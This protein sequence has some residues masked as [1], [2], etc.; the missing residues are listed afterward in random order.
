MQVFADGRATV[1]GWGVLRAAAAW[2]L[3][4]SEMSALAKIFPKFDDARPD[5]YGPG[6]FGGVSDMNC[7][8][9]MY[10]ETSS[11]VV[12]YYPTELFLRHRAC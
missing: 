3:S 4:P 5:F 11:K 8:E 1:S 12:R 7:D 9:L 6:D 2:R 10:Y